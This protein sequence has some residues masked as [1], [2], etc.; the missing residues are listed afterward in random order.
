MT[1]DEL[2]RAFGRVLTAGTRITTVALALGLLATFLMPGHQATT[3]L[4]T[5]GLLVL[6]LTPVARVMVAVIGY[7]HARDWWFVL[8]TSIV[9][10]LLIATFASAFER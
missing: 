3:V 10:G 1:G 5:T 7:I 4:L 8:Y 6:L 2:E 9:L